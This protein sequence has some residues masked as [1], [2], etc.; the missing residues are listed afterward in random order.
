MLSQSQHDHLLGCCTALIEAAS[1]RKRMKLVK[2]LEAK[3]S[4][5]FRMQGKAFM[6]GFKKLSSDFTE[7]KGESWEVLWRG[8]AKKTAKLLI[9]PIQASYT[10]SMKTGAAKSLGT[11]QAGISFDIKSPD[12]EAWLKDRAAERVAGIN[13]VTEE[14][15]RSVITAGREAGQSFEDIA[16]SIAGTFDGFAK[17][18]DSLARSR[19][20]LVAATEVGDAYCEGQLQQGKQLA[21]AGLEMEK[22]WITTGGNPCDICAGNEAAG[23]IP[24]DDQ[25]PSGDD[26]P[27]GHPRCFCDLQTRLKRERD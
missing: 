2:A 24:M 12:V 11:V 23:W 7:R 10:T 3:V 16:R 18:G 21:A 27:L 15:L 25:F 17:A 5:A 20:Y 4:R 22:A 14:R 26:R 6:A 8:I 19:A 1:D 9:D 13:D